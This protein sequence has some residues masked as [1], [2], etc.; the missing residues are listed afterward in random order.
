MEVTAAQQGFQAFAGSHLVMLAVFVAGIG[1]IIWWGRHHRG[2]PHERSRR[3]AFAILIAFFAGALQIYQ[4]TPGDY[5]LQTSWP[6][7]LCD[8]AVVAVVLALWT[9][10]RRATAFTY[11]VGLTLTIQA[12]LTPAL[13]SD[14][15][16]PRF[17]A[18]WGMHLG[19]VWAACYLTWGLGWRPTWR[20]WAFAV[21]A[22]AA[23][24][25]SVVAINLVL[26]TNYGYLMRKPSTAS[27]LDLLGPWPW[28]V[29]VEVLVIST[30]WLLVM[31]L[32]WEVRAGR[33]QRADEHA[34]R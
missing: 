14:F 30:F 15:P 22:T 17:L 4:F 13:A 10:G 27:V 6:F 26:G 7:Q 3:R 23:W 33:R 9:R 12:I 21:A 28:Y 5:S 25:V 18:F 1:A 16:D 29:L 19:I 31:T 8:V 11:Y 34:P 2:H 32:P 24:A 20:L